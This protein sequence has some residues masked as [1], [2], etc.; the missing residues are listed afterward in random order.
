MAEVPTKVKAGG[1]K[2][3]TTIFILAI[4]I[5][6]SAIGLYV[7]YEINS[8]AQSKP[9]VI[10]YTVGNTLLD[11][12]ML[13]QN[14]LS[15]EDG[16]SLLHYALFSYSAYNASS[17]TA[18]TTIYESKPPSGIYVLNTSD[19]CFNCG[20]TETIG[21]ALTSNLISYNL[22]KSS[23]E[24]SLAEISSLQKLPP[25]QRALLA[26]KYENGEAVNDIARR[27]GR[28]ANAV[29]ALLYRIREALAET[30]DI[31][32]EAVRQTL[33]QTPPELASDI[34]ERGIVLT[35][36][37]ALLRGLDKRLRQETNL[38]VNV[39]EDPL[40]CVV[41]GAGKVLEEFAKYGKVLERSRKD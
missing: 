16:R 1:I 18:N 33:E 39:A 22:I 6:L 36:G 15:Y 2:R 9:I 40:T 25:K 32:V 4:V 41:R 20:S 5:C 30:V 3:N 31:V 13:S 35:G 10:N 17:V 29:S 37:G 11:S 26:A 14:L 23:N 28:E 34:L 27:E 12:I 19:E 7:G 21:Y 8:A 38:P 24:L